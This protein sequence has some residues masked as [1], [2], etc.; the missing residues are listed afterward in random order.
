LSR[1]QLI[2]FECQG[3][4]PL[5]LHDDQGTIA[6]LSPPALAVGMCKPMARANQH[7][8][9]LRISTTTRL[10]SVVEEVS[11]FGLAEF[12]AAIP[13]F[14]WATLGYVWREGGGT[15]SQGVEKG[16][17][18]LLSTLHIWVTSVWCP[19]MSLLYG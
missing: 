5:H 16:M 9:V 8:W 3:L 18:E 11:P 10:T 4:V 1:L 13:K 14:Y 15:R 12:H 6:M 19:R 7:D 2:L 17:G